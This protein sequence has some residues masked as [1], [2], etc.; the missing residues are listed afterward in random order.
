M[1]VGGVGSCCAENFLTKDG[2]VQV[3]GSGGRG[4]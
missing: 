1:R 2:E 3:G 4:W